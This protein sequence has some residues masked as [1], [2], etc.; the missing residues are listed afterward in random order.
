MN[1]CPITYELINDNQQ[2]SDRGLKLLSPKLKNLNPLPLTAS[3]LRQ[4]ASKHASKMSIQGVQP[5]LSCIL[6]LKNEAFK[7]VDLGG[8]YILKPEHDA[9]AEV[10]QNEDLTMR[11]ASMIGI[12]VP[13]HGMVY[14]I[15]NSL[16]YFIKRFDRAGQADKLSIEDFSQLSGHTRTTKYNFSMEKIINIV[17]EYATFPVIEK[18]K[19][20]TRTIF[21]FLIGND[22]MHLKNF[23]MIMRNQKVELSPA[24]DFLNSS[25]I[26]SSKEEISLPLAGKKHNLSRKDLVDYFGV[27]RM[28]LPKKIIDSQLE[29]IEQKISEWKDLIDICFLSD[30][31]KQKYNNILD[32]RAN[33]LWHLYL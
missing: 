25:I 33:R 4:E 29:V 28:R 30:N 9:Y 21:N 27:D 26:I 23:S 20:F 14:G 19:L 17:D 15:D 13:L 5:K 6:S 8:R 18:T 32:E 16:T 31:M 10:P 22:D 12:E 24:Y 7:I 2:Y 3:E 1:I 11:L